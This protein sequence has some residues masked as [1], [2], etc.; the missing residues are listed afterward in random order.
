MAKKFR[1]FVFPETTKKQIDS[2]P[3]DMK[4]RFYEAVTNYGMYDM[5]PE[6]LSTIENIIWIPMKD[7]LDSCK[8]DKPGAPAGNSNAAKKSDVSKEPKTEKQDVVCNAQDSFCPE[9][10][11]VDFP[12]TIQDNENNQNNIDLDKNNQNNIVFEKNNKTTLNNGNHKGKGN[13]NCNLNLNKNEKQCADV[14]NSFGDLQKEAFTLLNEHNTNRD[15][16]KERKVP[17]SHDLISFAQKESRDLASLVQKGESPGN[18]LAGLR[19]YLAL[20]KNTSVWK[21]YYSWQDF[22]KNFVNF[23]PEN[24]SAERF[25]NQSKSERAIDKVDHPDDIMDRIVF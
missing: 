23:S 2:M 21:T 18:V 12:E 9:Q 24:F 15:I 25:M 22:I 6:N 10:A 3:D 7:L 14:E 13:D 5:E 16:P 4:L 20:A 17:V 1:S 11:D 8:C 19:N